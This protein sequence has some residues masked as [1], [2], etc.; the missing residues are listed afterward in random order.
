MGGFLLATGQLLRPRIGLMAGIS[1][2]IGALLARAELGTALAAA[3]VGFLLCAACSVLN[4]VQERRI[5]ARMPRTALRPLAS[6]ALCPF[7][8]AALG[9]ALLALAGLAAFA[10]GGV[11]AALVV[12]I[13]ALLYNGLYTPLKRVTPHAVLIGAVPGALPPVF[14]WLLAGAAPDALRSPSIWALFA[15]YYLWQAPHFWTLAER[16]RAEYARAGLAVAP[17]AL[18]PGRYPLVHAFWTAAFLLGLAAS[19]VLGVV[20][21]GPLRYALLGLALLSGLAAA[22][23]AMRTS[24]RRSPAGPFRLADAAMFAFLALICLDALP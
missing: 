6:G 15:V 24:R 1:T 14:G 4:Q 18:G 23:R 3:G 21:S 12:P 7:A 8:G 20:E 22:L 11:I 16:R 2:G 5:D 13:T 9:L 10:L 19:A 17:L